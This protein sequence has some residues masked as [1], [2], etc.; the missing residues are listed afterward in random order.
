MRNKFGPK[1]FT[2]KMVCRWGPYSSAESVNR[3]I[4]KIEAAAKRREKRAGVMATSVVYKVAQEK[5]GHAVA[6]ELCHAVTEHERA[7]KRV[8]KAVK[9]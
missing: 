9:G 5:Y 8:R 3:L 6:L 7:L 4:D 2:A 1:A